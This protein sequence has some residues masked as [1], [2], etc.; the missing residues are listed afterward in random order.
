MLLAVEISTQQGESKEKQDM[1]NNPQREREKKVRKLCPPNP[2]ASDVAKLVCHMLSG[3]FYSESTARKVTN[4]KI[5][6]LIQ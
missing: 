1:N 6:W 5:K 2:F 4:E 3:V